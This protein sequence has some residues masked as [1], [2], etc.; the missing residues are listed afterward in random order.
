MCNTHPVRDAPNYGGIL[1]D[2]VGI[3]LMPT[4][5]KS[6]AEKGTKEVKMVGVVRRM[7]VHANAA[8]VLQFMMKTI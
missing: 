2:G 6:Y 8:G 5:N 1:S 4:R 7:V 3:L